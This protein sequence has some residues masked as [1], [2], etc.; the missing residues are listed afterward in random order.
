[1]GFIVI[2]SLSQCFMILSLHTNII[3]SA[4]FMFFLFEKFF[5]KKKYKLVVILF[6]N[7]FFS[8]DKTGSKILNFVHV[9]NLK[10]ME[11]VP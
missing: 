2:A 10:T 1:V 9:M 6:E 4:V 11:K 7:D 8:K 5:D 3:L